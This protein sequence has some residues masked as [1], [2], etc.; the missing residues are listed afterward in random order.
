MSG[1]RERHQGIPGSRI[2]RLTIFSIMALGTSQAAF[3]GVLTQIPTLF[4]TGFGTADPHYTVTRCAAN[5]T[6]VCYSSGSE[7]GVQVTGA[8]LG[9]SQSFGVPVSWP[10]VASG[11]LVPYWDPTSY[12]KV[13]NLGPIP[14]RWIS[15][16]A[17]AMNPD[18]PGFAYDF[19]TSFDLT[20]F[21]I[22]TVNISGYWSM[23]NYSLGIYVNGTL[24]PGT[25]MDPTVQPVSG[26]CPGGLK[27]CGGAVDFAYQVLWTFSIPTNLLV[28]GVN[29]LDFLVQN[30]SRPQ[31]NPV[32]AIVDFTTES[33]ILN[34]PEPGTALLL[35]FGV[36]AIAAQRRYRR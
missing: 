15:N 13:T 2:A 22:T 31:P 25:V 17:D 26:T 18:A 30:D 19:H 6:T 29:T 27:A 5:Q 21:D 9:Q 20:Y 35:A 36:I 16:V 12:D 8:T 14:N 33:G 7:A 4:G 23:D 24:V 34:A 11:Q 10:L 28:Q 1:S 32:A 3:A